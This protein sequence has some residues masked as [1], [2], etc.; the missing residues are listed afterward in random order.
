MSDVSRARSE[1][2][3][4]VAE[5]EHSLN[6][7]I[8]A[9]RIMEGYES[10]YADNIVMQEL[11][12]EPCHGKDAN[13]QRQ[14]QFFG[15]VQ[16]VHSVQLLGGALAGNQAYSEWEYD[17][18]FKDGLRYRLTEVAVREWTEGRVVRERFYWDRS[19]YPYEV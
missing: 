10:F 14:N 12:D 2:A 15:L 5:L 9:G 19:N 11:S 13:R 3:K 18:S 1:D 7:L 6:Q 16:E 4:P 8:L 17:I